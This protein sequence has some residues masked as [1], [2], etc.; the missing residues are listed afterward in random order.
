MVVDK[1][2]A[3]HIFKTVERAA[4][5]RRDVCVKKLIPKMKRQL[6][7]GL[8]G[9]HGWLRLRTAW[10]LHEAARNYPGGRSPITVFEIGC[11]QGRTTIA[12][13]LGLKQRGAGKVHAV[14][15]H[16]GSEQTLSLCGPTNSYEPFLANIARAGV[17]DFVVPRRATSHQAWR[18]FRG[19]RVH[20]LVLDASKSYRDVLEYV[21]DWSPLLAD[22][23]LVFFR[24]AELI[25]SA[26]RRCVLKQGTAFRHPSLLRDDTGTVLRVEFR[27]R[28]PWRVRDNVA[29]RRI[30]DAIK[31]LR[32]N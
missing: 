4:V 6:S 2:F 26:L 17:G 10:I 1:V 11:W 16:T 25:V 28:S 32:E 13:A 24:D 19:R 3:D 27:P 20:I 18:S 21:D 7:S 30:L 29:L 8:K 9:V 5:T 14:D 22:G 31:K 15:P 23:A 12:L